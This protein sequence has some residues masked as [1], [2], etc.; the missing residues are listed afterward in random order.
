MLVLISGCLAA[1]ASPCAE[2]LRLSLKEAIRSALADNLQVTIAQ[3]D[4][5]KTR[6]EA[7]SHAGAFD[8]NLVADAQAGWVT[9]FS[10]HP[11][12]AAPGLAQKMASVDHS[13]T[14]GLDKPS[15]LPL[16][17]RPAQK[18]LMYKIFINS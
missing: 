17:P 6:A 15:R 10:S 2:V 13:V 16:V 4:C 11:Q 7:R 14:A 8:W 1:Q 5:A 9:T 12:P 18:F 3:E